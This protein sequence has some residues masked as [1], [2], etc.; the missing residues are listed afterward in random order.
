[1]FGG[2][3][4]RVYPTASVP[5]EYDMIKA[6]REQTKAVKD[7]RKKIDAKNKSIASVRS[8]IMKLVPSMLGGTM[9]SPQEIITMMGKSGEPY[10]PATDPVSL[11][12]LARAGE[13]DAMANEEALTRA[14]E[15]AKKARRRSSLQLIPQ[16]MKNL[17]NSRV[18]M[19]NA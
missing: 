2:S 19:K 13:M 5:S 10:R 8:D 14:V 17:T 1:M 11:R 6:N 16:Y 15:E 4:S 3:K 7:L 12:W 18:G 9:D